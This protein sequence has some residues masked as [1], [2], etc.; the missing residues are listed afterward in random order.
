MWALLESIFILWGEVFFA[1]GF[2]CYCRFMDFRDSIISLVTEFRVPCLQFTLINP[3]Q[4]LKFFSGENDD[5]RGGNKAKVQG[6]NNRNIAVYYAPLTLLLAHPT[7]VE[8]SVPRRKATRRV[9]KKISTPKQDLQSLQGS[10]TVGRGMEGLGG[11]NRTERDDAGEV[12]KT[13]LAMSML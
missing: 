4:T 11:A 8:G 6:R 2:L 9:S 5:D 1:F 3:W 10:G 7:K 12:R 13:I